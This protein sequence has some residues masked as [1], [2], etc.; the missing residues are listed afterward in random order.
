MTATTRRDFLRVGLGTA[1][2][3]GTGELS[4]GRAHATP[5]FFD[6]PFTLGVASGDPT[7]DGVVLWTRLAPDPLA[8][9][10]MPNRPVPV[11]WEVASDER[12]RRVVARGTQAAV[13]QSAHSVHVEV[14]GLRSGA[15]YWYRFR[16]GRI[17]S[18]V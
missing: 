7:S 4:S 13:P 11:Q 5:S 16:S 17:L 2:L 3:L 10:G 9:G 15:W 8:G 1:V 12:F 14:R 18:P 6:D